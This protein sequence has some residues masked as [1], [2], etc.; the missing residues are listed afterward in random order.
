[1]VKRGKFERWLDRHNHKMELVR[2]IVPL[3][4]LI[5][6][7]LMFFAFF[8]PRQET[9]IIEKQMPAPQPIIIEND[10]WDCH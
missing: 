7:A 5:L 4:V 6:Q 8:S 2:T 9:I 1:M 3:A 10:C